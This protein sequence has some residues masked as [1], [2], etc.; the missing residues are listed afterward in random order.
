MKPSESSPIAVS[1]IVVSSERRRPM[2]PRVCCRSCE[3]V[4]PLDDVRQSVD[5]ST[6]RPE[7]PRLR[8]PTGSR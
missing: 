4:I 8:S 3:I 7:L 1:L 5:L 6:E 2:E